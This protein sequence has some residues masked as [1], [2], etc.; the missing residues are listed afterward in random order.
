MSDHG[1]TPRWARFKYI[2]T[3]TL[4]V[5][6]S[7]VTGG[8]SSVIIINQT[9][10]DNGIFETLLVSDKLYVIDGA[11]DITGHSI[12]VPTG[13]VEFEGLGFNVS[14]ITTTDDGT[15]IFTSPVGG[16]GDLLFKD[17]AFTASGVGS[18]VFALTDS[19]GTHAVEYARVNFNNCSSLGYIDGYRQGLEVGTGRFGGTPDLEFRGVWA[20][21]YFVQ[22]SIARSLTDSVY[23]LFKSAVGHT[24]ASR[25]G[26]NP[27][28][29]IPAN[30][31]AFEMT[32]A[33]F[34]FDELLQIDGANFSGDG[35][36]FSGIDE[37]NTRVRVKNT[38]GTPNTFVGGFWVL[39]ATAP[40]ATA[41][42]NTFY[43]LA[44]TTTGSSLVWFTLPGDNNLTSNS[45]ETV[46]TMAT[47]TGSFSGGNNKVFKI[48]F[49]V[50]DNSA[51]AYV[52]SNETQF[53]TGG[54][55]RFES[56]TLFSPR[57]SLDEND[58]IEVWVANTTDGSSITADV[59]THFFAREA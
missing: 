59:D 16:S 45:T 26:G 10:V 9:T 54:T 14:S 33:N 58:R 12:E 34:A 13:G 17:I 4:C 43:K 31:T 11:L 37:T 23:S 35:A 8:A 42:Q 2:A 55:G 46:Q 53:T 19:D 52:D 22:L 24:F 18:S 21:G 57:L 6:G 44:G 39:S 47:F 36:V 20:G 25:F 3:T 5:N 1:Y 48:R 29:L 27:N 41:V 50:W 28:I 51:A 15:Q 30:V 7:E 40:T 56:V 38:R 32:S 49:R